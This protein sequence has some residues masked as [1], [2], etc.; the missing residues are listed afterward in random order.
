MGRMRMMMRR[1][2]KIRVRMIGWGKMWRD[3]KDKESMRRKVRRMR[4]R[5]EKRKME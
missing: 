3:E 1:R 5:S 2:R 4:R